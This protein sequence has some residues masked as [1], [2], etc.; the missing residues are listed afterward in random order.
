M[1][2]GIE[3]EEVQPGMRWVGVEYDGD[4]FVRGVEEM[5]F[6]E[7]SGYNFPVIMQRIVSAA[8][9]AVGYGAEGAFATRLV[10]HMPP[11]STDNRFR[12]TVEIIPAAGPTPAEE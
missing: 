12:V 1:V 6:G 7:D 5:S 10:G 4:R 11:F 2:G 3:L 8:H 9:R